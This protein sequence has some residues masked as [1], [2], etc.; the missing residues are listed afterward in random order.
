M[1][2]V[3][4]LLAVAVLL[5]P[6]AAI[7]TSG[8]VN[9]NSELS[10][11][12]VQVAASNGNL[13]RTV[14]VQLQLA[15]PSSEIVAMDIPLRYGQAGDG[16]NLTNVTYSSRVD[17]FDVKVTNIDND[18]K[19]VIIGLI[20]MATDPTTP[21]LSKGDGPIAALRFE[22]TDPTISEFTI[23]PT[24]MERPSHRLM[25]VSHDYSSGQPE[26]VWQEKNVLDPQTV[27]IAAGTGS[28]PD[29]Y[30][31]NQNYPNP[32]NA[33]TVITFDLAQNSDWNLTVYNLLGQAVRTFSGN[34][35]RGKNYNLTWDGTSDDGRRVAS[36][37]YFYRFSA[38]GYTETKKMTLLK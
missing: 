38:N 32:F 23:E 14:T 22:V 10:L 8:P 35:V 21:D 5:I 31:L 1:R 19:T 29:S 37:V 2:K 18:A 16:I 15:N 28:L 12:Q 3:I 33:G 34:D 7:A 25:L 27:Q 11:G 17:Y 30:R 9:L 24:T 20:A 36:G 13:V 6:A 4:T 26:V